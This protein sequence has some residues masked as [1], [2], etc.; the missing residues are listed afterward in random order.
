MFCKQ[1]P[2][3][4]LCSSTKRV[5]NWPHRDNLDYAKNTFISK[6]WEHN[7][8][9]MCGT[10]ATQPVTSYDTTHSRTHYG[11]LVLKCDTSDFIV[12]EGVCFMAKKPWG[13]TR[14]SRSLIPIQ[15]SVSCIDRLNY[16]LN[17][18]RLDV[19]N[20]NML[21]CQLYNTYMITRMAV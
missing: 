12:F 19:S 4:L 16:L 9:W 2:I 3:I 15:H 13:K 7:L 1:N 21:L 8:I 18:M 10:S 11:C 17:G 6:S 5:K 14:F 20:T